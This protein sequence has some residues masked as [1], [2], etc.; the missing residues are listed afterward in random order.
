MSKF[1]QLN[2]DRAVNLDAITRLD[3][4]ANGTL[5]SIGDI[6]L[7]TDIPYETM[8]SF[9]NVNARDKEASQGIDPSLVDGLKG[10]VSNFGQPKP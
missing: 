4:M 9:A 3:R 7:I 1:I 10:L 8:L 6:E 5:V 2:E